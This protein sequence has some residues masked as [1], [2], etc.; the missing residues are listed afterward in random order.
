M[1]PKVIFFAIL[2]RVLLR[3]RVKKH[4]RRIGELFLILRI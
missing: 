3:D 2:R 4:K 1:W